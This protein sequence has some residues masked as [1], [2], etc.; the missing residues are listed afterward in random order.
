MGIVCIGGREVSQAICCT[1]TQPVNNVSGDGTYDIGMKD[2]LANGMRGTRYQEIDSV[3]KI[4]VEIWNRRTVSKALEGMRG[5][6][7]RNHHLPRRWFSASNEY[8]FG[9]P[10]DSVSS[11]SRQA[12]RPN[13]GLS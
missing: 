1:G 12:P 9:R 11:V 10:P 13:L 6:Y 3:M 7:K 4:I 8:A 5:P 2:D